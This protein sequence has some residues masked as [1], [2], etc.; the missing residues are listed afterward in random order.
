MEVT[1][2][3]CTKVVRESCTFLSQKELLHTYTVLIV[4]D[5]DIHGSDWGILHESGLGILHI[6]SQKELLHTYS[7]ALVQDSDI[8]S[9]GWGILHE[10][11]QGI[12]HGLHSK[13]ESCTRTM[14]ILHVIVGILHV[15]THV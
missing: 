8:H 13:Q 9:S 1:G 10:S 15:P 14:G 2:E 3:S 5:S 6:L 12:L 4:Q 7:P 11:G